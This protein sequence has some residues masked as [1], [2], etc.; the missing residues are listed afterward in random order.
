MVNS[1]TDGYIS[2]VFCYVWRLTHIFRVCL[3]VVSYYVHEIKI[4][5]VLVCNGYHFYV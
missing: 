5:G 3:Y 2:M 4:W 1:G